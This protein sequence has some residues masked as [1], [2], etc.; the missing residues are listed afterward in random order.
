MTA[1]TVSPGTTFPTVTLSTGVSG[2]LVIPALQDITINNAND[3]YSWTQLNSASKL[4]VATT[5]TNSVSSNMV[6]E[7]ATFFGSNIAGSTPAEIG[8]FGLS[9]NKTLCS[10]TITNVG[11]KTLSGSCYVTGL[12]PKVSADQPV[13]VTPV[14]LTVTGDFTVA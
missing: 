1:A 5:S 3:V 12:A 2:N 6:V 7:N 14:T 11:N 10:F 4:Q 8:I 13:W 9:H